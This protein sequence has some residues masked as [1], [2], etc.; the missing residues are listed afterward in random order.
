MD[1]TTIA[2]V[3][4]QATHDVDLSLK[5]HLDHIDQAADAGADLVVFPEISLQGY[6]SILD[7][8]NR[9]SVLTDVYRTA[10]VVPAGPS[11][12]QIAAKAAEREIYVVFGLTEAGPQPA[13]VYNTAVLAGPAGYLGKYRKV[14]VSISEQA[15]WRRG[16]DW[17]VFNT[18]FGRIGILICYD[19]MWPEACRELLFRGADIFVMPTAW[20]YSEDDH[21]PDTNV[22]CHQ[23]RLFDQVRA[24]ENQRWFVSSNFYGNF[25]GSDFFG[26]SQIVDPLGRIVASSGTASGL[27]MATVDIR[28]GIAEAAATLNGARLVR[29]RRPETYQAIRGEIPITIDG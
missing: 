29:D 20:R 26:F 17:P 18:P 22:S 3:A 4:M 12:S 2:T 23:Y 8:R 21:D 7:R 9:T 27:V 11:V 28:A 13:V 25:E 5:T 10:E 16:N 6:P 15:I 24:A 14:H 19:K 1:E